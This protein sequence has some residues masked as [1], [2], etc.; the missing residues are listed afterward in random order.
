MRACLVLATCV[1][2]AAAAADEDP[3]VRL[4]ERVCGRALAAVALAV[5]FDRQDRWLH[6]I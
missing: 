5:A 2:F 3:I 4:T 6:T 1:A